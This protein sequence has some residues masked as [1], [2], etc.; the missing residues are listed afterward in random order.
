[1]GIQIT[2]GRKFKPG[3]G[4]VYIFNGGL[5]EDARG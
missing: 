4:D 3:D 2:E 5:P 1:M